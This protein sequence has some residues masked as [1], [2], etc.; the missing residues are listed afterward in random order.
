MFCP[1]CGSEYRPGFFTCVD[2]EVP[3]V[4]RPPARVSAAGLDDGDSEAGMVTVYDAEDAE[5]LEAAV[6]RLRQAE[7]V[8]S[9]GGIEGSQLASRGDVSFGPDSYLAP[10][11]VQVRDADAAM[12]RPWLT[13]LD[14]AI[15]AD[16]D[17]LDHYGLGNQYGEGCDLVYCPRCG[18]SQAARLGA[19][20]DCGGPT[21]AKLPR[22]WR[23]P[24]EAV[25]STGR[26]ALLEAARQALAKAGIRH[27]WGPLDHL[28][29][30]PAARSSDSIP[31]YGLPP[32]LIRVKPAAA[33]AEA[34]RLLALAP[35]LA[36]A[37]IQPGQPA[38]SGPA[39]AP[40]AAA[41]AARPDRSTA[42][43]PGGLPPGA[44]RREPGVV[45]CPVCLEEYR[46]GTATCVDCGAALVEELPPEPEA[47]SGAAAAW[48]EEEVAEETEERSESGDERDDG[49][50]DDDDPEEDDEEDAEDDEEDDAEEDDEDD[51]DE[52]GEGRDGRDGRHGIVL[53][54]DA[55]AMRLAEEPYRAARALAVSSILFPWI[56]AP[57]AW[58]RAE[59]ALD[60]YRRGGLQDPHLETA[61]RRVRL[62][63]AALTCGSWA[64]TLY[65]VWR[66]PSW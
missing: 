61:I 63:A 23:Q 17:A 54:G 56:V 53:P 57:L 59:L 14:E 66:L 32:G 46:A 24:E 25:F 51:E 65:Y 47:E 64:A 41:A 31:D 15:A 45:F 26:T 39:A 29:Y 60:G 33:A 18:I 34:R 62:F 28:P 10:G 37:L 22:D 3:L 5:H 1:V 38:A 19:C 8:H 55:A 20:V 48:D 6:L 42:A 36:P 27:S 50:E 7:I 44:G 49:D 52:T 13:N 30:D 9:W 16:R 43:A 11:E 2:C 40:A 12:A 4:D 58:R 35:A 21:V